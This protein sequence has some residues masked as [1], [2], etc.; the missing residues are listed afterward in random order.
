MKWDNCSN[1]DGVSPF[2]K[3]FEVAILIVYVRVILA[4]VVM[5]VHMI[6]ERRLLST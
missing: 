2:F 6:R 4:L 5:S 1:G 3:L